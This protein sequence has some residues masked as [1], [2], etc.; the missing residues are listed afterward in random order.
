[1]IVKSPTQTEEGEV[2]GEVQLEP[3]APHTVYPYLDFYPEYCFVLVVKDFREE[4]ATGYVV[5]AL[6]TKEYVRRSDEEY[7][8]S[9]LKERP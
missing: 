9:Q 8:R 4:Y 3:L 6:N 2:K 7:I 5:C 1:M